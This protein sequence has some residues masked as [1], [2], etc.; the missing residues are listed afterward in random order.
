MNRGGW[1]KLIGLTVAAVACSLGG[2]VERRY[3]I[4]TDQQ[5]GAIAY[6]NGKPLG[7]TPA[8]NSFVYYGKY[9]F[10]LVANGYQTLQV[11]ECIPTPWYEYP[12]L[13]FISENLVPW[14]I[15]D[16]H[17]FNYTLQPVPVANVTEDLQKAEGLRGRGRAVQPPPQDPNSLRPEPV[18]AVLGPPVR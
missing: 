14:T 10:T 9:H 3:V 18:S 7:A 8:D 2:C 17:H 4:T 16:V 15:R 12:G 11:D 1:E 5:P 6:E 13:D